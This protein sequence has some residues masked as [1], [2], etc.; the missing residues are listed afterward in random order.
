M[1]KIRIGAVLL[2]FLLTLGGVFYLY[3]NVRVNVELPTSARILA[4]K[5]SFPLAVRVEPDLPL[6]KLEIDIVQGTQRVVLY[7][8]KPPKEALNFE[9]DTAQAGL[10]DGKALLVVKLLLP[11]GEKTAYTEEIAVDS[12]PPAVEVLH[13]PRRLIIGEP[14]VLTV[15]ASEDTENIY[16]ALGE[17]KFPLLKA[18]D[19]TYKT[20]FVAPLFLL[21]KPERFYIVATDRAGNVTRK[22]LPVVIK[23]KKFRQVRIELTDSLLERI[24]LKYFND[25]QNALEKFKVINEEYRKEDRQRLVEICSNSEGVFYPSGAFKQLPGSKPTAYFGDHRSYYYKGKLVS[26]SVHKGLDLAKYRHAPVVAANDGKV[27]FVGRLKIYGNVVL[28]DHGYGLFTLYAHLNDATVKEGDTVKK[29]EVI[30]HTDTTGLALG[31]HLHFGVL[32][33]GYAANPIFFFDGKYLG[34]YLYPYFGE[35]K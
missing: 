7:R 24:V 34:Y 12:T 14:G 15:K 27:A 9:I 8:G 29:G 4:K 35:K 32:A 18:G 31:D 6:L 28:I 19:G 30:G 3:S 25:T 1:R 11:W 5:E 21:Q 26:R 20:V 33:W 2:A 22:F 13:K 17:A 10:K 23:P 16:L